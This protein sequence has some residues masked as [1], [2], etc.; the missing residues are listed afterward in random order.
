M[1]WAPVVTLAV[2]LAAGVALVR[3]TVP[4]A[5]T[6]VA[7]VTVLLL[8]GVVTPQEA[9]GGFSNPAPITVAALFVVARAVERTGALQPLVR[10]ILGRGAGPRASLMRLLVPTAAVS[11]FMNNTPVVAMMT[12]QV[13]E[14]A[15]REGR[16]PSW[17]LMPLSFA[18]ILGGTMTLVGTSTN[19]VVSGL[20]EDR[21]LSP[22]TM[23][24]LLPL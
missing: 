8:A 23:F 24:E 14:W 4:P 6:M 21:G 20:M 22:L 17:Y 12:P 13:T 10:R 11:A 19:I 7:S 5:T 9:F 16:P 15:H 3:G 1:S 18:T 2:V